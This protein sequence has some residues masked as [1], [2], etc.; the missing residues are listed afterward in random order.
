MGFQRKSLR[1]WR[2]TQRNSFSYRLRKRKLM[3]SCQMALKAMGK[4]L[5]SLKSKS[6]TGEIG[7]SLMFG[8]LPKE[9]WDF[10]L[11]IP[12]LL[13]KILISVDTIFKNW[14]WRLWVWS[15]FVCV[16][17]CVWVVPDT[18]HHSLALFCPFHTCIHKKTPFRNVLL[19][20]VKYFN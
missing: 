7:S 16:R 17:A 1:K 19:S 15:C 14:H 10:G 18:R 13:G 4:P 9:M 5:F 3:H 11:L 8:L 6:L 20:A 2:L 12:P